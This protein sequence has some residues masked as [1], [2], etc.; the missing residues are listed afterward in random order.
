MAKRFTVGISEGAIH[1]T[2]SFS[3]RVYRR[4]VLANN[5]IEALSKCLPEI[6]RKVLPKVDEEIR[7]VSVNVGETYSVTG[8]A[9]RLTPIQINAR[10]GRIRLRR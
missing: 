4:R 7:Y 10:T 9:S 2:G 3:R 6:R 8:S 1:R 5:R